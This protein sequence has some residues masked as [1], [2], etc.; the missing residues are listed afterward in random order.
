MKI[1]T[2]M[3]GLALLTIGWLLGRQGGTPP[4][5]AAGDGVAVVAAPS[6]VSGTPDRARAAPAMRVP[7]SP[8]PSSSAVA[9]A[10]IPDHAD[11]RE[12]QPD[13]AS[14]PAA[15]YR[16]LRAEPIDPVAAMRARHA[17]DDGLIKVPYLDRTSLRVRCAATLC[18]VH[19]DFMPGLS[20]ENINV[21]M[22]ALQ[23]D[24]LR[25][26]LHTA[27]L[28]MVAASFGPDGFTLYTQRRPD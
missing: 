10:Y 15:L 19:G 17:I 22:Q 8:A 11:A 9:R 7:P 25:T 12:A 18:E 5:S 16:R 3:A 1:V 28:T 26:P 2:G 23:G 24:T 4:A 6:A 14:A 13:P 20:S 27:G 21:G